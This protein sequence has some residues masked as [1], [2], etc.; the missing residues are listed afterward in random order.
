MRSLQRLI[1]ACRSVLPL[2]WAR[3][4]VAR[5]PRIERL[6]A[7]RIVRLVVI[8]GP[9]FGIF[10]IA[11]M[12]VSSTNWFCNRCH[13]MHSFHESWQAS[14]HKE[15]NCADCHI[16]PGFRHFVAAKVNGM[17]QLVDNVL[18]RTSGNPSAWV[19]DAA[20]LRSGCHVEAEVRAKKIEERFIF[21]HDKHVGLEYDG[22]TVRC[23]VCHS[24]ISG[25]QHFEIN[26][27]VCMACH[28]MSYPEPGSAT[29]PAN[30]ATSRAASRP[31]T[32]NPSQLPL[33]Q[34]ATTTEKVP[35]RECKKCHVPPKEPVEY[36]G[37][38][39]VH[40]KYLAYGAACE[41]CHHGVT[42]KPQKIEN[43]H[44]FSCHSF[45]MAETV[46]SQELHRQ[47]SHG[48]HKVECFG[49]HGLISHGTK[50]MA[51][52]LNEFDCQSCHRSAHI[53]Q[54]TTYGVARSFDGLGA[55]SQPAVT[56]STA[57]RPATTQPA[58]KFMITPMFLAHV[59][60]T[61]CH[62]QQQDLS[63]KPGIG[64]VAVASAASCD[65]CHE[66]GLGDKMVPL[67]QRNTREL[68][69]TLTK[70]MPATKPTDDRATQ[71]VAEARSLLDFVK[72]D[73]SWGVHNPRYTQELLELGRSKLV[74]AATQ[75]AE[76]PAGATE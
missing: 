44:C 1:Q 21:E 33:V 64:T 74:A 11:F 15:A 12:Y 55:G 23:T 32:T 4:F 61:A 8:G 69:E 41:S 72:L 70:M 17:G 75:P 57:T 60:C 7:R 22:V 20:C 65:R 50:A 73:G 53:V 52:R 14:A 26:T 6:W 42:A 35:A 25:D 30:L 39:V 59:D 45:G 31:A 19:E 43:R 49:C 27:N 37:L 34:V 54:R 40:D 3:R 68:H 46:D 66:R 9:L 51:M 16:E 76:K 18:G 36:R 67:W 5:H 71:L 56:Q 38:K 28:L 63:V 29:Q 62:V 47:H 48:S 24:H 58:D 13:V 2:P 10:N